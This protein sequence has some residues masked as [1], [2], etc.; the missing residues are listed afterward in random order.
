MVS[1]SNIFIGG[2]DAASCWKD[3][4]AEAMIAYPGSEIAC[5]ERGLGIVLAE[6]AG[7]R[8]VQDLRVWK[9]KE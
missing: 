1:I 3:L 4:V 9:D 5:Y 6:G 2:L 7:F 8:R